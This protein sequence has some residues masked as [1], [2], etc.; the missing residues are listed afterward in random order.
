L[1][2]TG[3]LAL[4]SQKCDYHTTT[5]GRWEWADRGADTI[6]ADHFKREFLVQ[7]PDGRMSSEVNYDSGGI[8]HTAE[9]TMNGG[10]LSV[11][12]PQPPKL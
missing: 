11:A 6:S 4:L 5:G 3:I 10:R 8:W 1:A 2:I 9:L 12:S 7:M